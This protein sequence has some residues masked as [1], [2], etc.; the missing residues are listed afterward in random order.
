MLLAY[1]LTGSIVYS[2]MVFDTG[3]GADFS[4]LLERCFRFYLFLAVFLHSLPG[5]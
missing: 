2:V 1:M 4:L 5:C 3:F